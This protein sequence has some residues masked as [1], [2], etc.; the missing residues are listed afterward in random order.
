MLS[1]ITQQTGRGVQIESPIATFWMWDAFRGRIGGSSLY[2]DGAILTYQLR[3][4]GIEIAAAVMT[5]LLALA[6]AALLVSPC[7]AIRRGIAVGEVLPP[8]V[9][10]D[11]DGP[12]PVQQGGLAAVRRLARGT[13]R[14]RARRGADLG[15]TGVPGAVAAGA[16]H[17]RA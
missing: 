8:L 10:G 4:P 7:V 1:F 6:V 16:R 12:H 9:S 2:Y 13:D 3:G 5:P 17:R 14:V 11:H 15:R